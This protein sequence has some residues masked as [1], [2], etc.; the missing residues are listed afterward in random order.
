MGYDG[1]ISNLQGSI[2]S[3]FSGFGKFDDDRQDA[4]DD[5]QRDYWE[6]IAVKIGNSAA[7]KIADDRQAGAPKKTANYVVRKKSTVV[8]LPGAS[9]D[10]RK[11]ADDWDKA[12]QNNSFF[13]VF[14]VELLRFHKMVRLEKTRL[15]ARK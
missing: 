1:D 11:S 13:A 15:R 8:H 9:D 14:F 10:R 5:Y 3:R 4:D 6:Q 12:R 7:E 2:I